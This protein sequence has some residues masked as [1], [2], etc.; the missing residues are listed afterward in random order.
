MGFW[1]TLVNLQQQA[2][3]RAFCGRLPWEG[4]LETQR[5]D[6]ETTELQFLFCKRDF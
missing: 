2:G 4:D 3:I 1:C 5:L 6:H